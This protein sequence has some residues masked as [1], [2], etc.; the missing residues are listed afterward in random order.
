MD[1]SRPLVDSFVDEVRALL[2]RQWP[3]QVGRDAPLVRREQE[4]ADVLLPHAQLR[5]FALAARIWPG[6]SI[7]Y[8]V[9]YHNLQRSDFFDIAAADA[10]VA[11]FRHDDDELVQVTLFEFERQLHAPLHV[12]RRRHSGGGLVATEV[13]LRGV[14]GLPDLKLW[15]GRRGVLSRLRVV[16]AA[17][18]ETT[19]M[20][21]AGFELVARAAPPRDV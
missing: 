7:V 15:Q 16:G 13:W 12:L 3:P 10:S 8:W 1:T 2:Q 9:Q 17:I 14:C 20:V 19:S 18:W 4:G 5:Q 6:Q 11:T 21:D